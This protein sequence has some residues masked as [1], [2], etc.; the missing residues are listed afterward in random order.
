[1]PRWTS[2]SLMSILNATFC[3][4][5]NMHDLRKA[6]RCDFHNFPPTTTQ[7]SAITD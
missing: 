2:D 5:S 4:T 7:V 6:R 1:M 3:E